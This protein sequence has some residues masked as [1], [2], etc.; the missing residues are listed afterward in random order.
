MLGQVNLLAADL[1]ACA[2]LA[3]K[4]GLIEQVAALALLP[5]CCHVAPPVTRACQCAPPW[6]CALKP[7]QDDDYMQAMR[8]DMRGNPMLMGEVTTRAAHG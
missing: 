3:W 1:T 4:P 7:F 8:G 2:G 6:T 5:A